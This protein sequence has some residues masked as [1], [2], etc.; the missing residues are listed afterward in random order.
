ML[1]SLAFVSAIHSLHILLELGHELL[2]FLSI[3]SS[4]LIE[5]LLQVLLHSIEVCFV[6]VVHFAVLFTP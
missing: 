4:L 5:L 2:N 6:G 3:I 1:A